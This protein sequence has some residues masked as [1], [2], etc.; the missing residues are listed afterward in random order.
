MLPR[1]DPRLTALRLPLLALLLTGCA[2]ASLTPRPT[3]GPEIPL[4]PAVARQPLP[5]PLCSQG[6]SSGLS[7]LLDSLVSTPTPPQLP[8]APASGP[9]TD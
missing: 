2:S 8:A 4:L 9:S 7:A 5:P 3:P 6:C 1:S